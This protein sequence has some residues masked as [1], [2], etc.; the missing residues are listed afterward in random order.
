MNST[1]EKEEVTSTNAPPRC[2]HRTTIQA[3]HRKHL[4]LH[5]MRTDTWVL[6]RISNQYNEHGRWYEMHWRR[7]SRNNNVSGFLPTPFKTPSNKPGFSNAPF[8]AVNILADCYDVFHGSSSRQQHDVWPNCALPP[9][10]N[11]SA[12]VMPP[13]HND[14]T[15][16][17]STLRRRWWNHWHFY[18][19]QF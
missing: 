1:F 17:A 15:G 10:F 7:W 12:M 9:L 2:Y 16:T 5:T 13:L 18:L 3:E 14:F 4:A 8:E 6:V 19:S 11:K